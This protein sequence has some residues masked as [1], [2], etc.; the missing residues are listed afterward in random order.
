MYICYINLRF[1]K[2]LNP[3]NSNWTA[4][5][6]F[7]RINI[8]LPTYF[9]PAKTVAQSH[10]NRTLTAVEPHLVALSLQLRSGFVREKHRFSPAPFFKRGI[11]LEQRG[12]LRATDY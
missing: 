3:H 12:N 1:L 4:T 8:L 6:L 10:P 9:N 11:F 5:F 7:P 2:F